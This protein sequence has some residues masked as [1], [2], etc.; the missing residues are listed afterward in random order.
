MILSLL[1]LACAP[2]PQPANTWIVDGQGGGHFTT[3]QAAIDAS[4]PGDFIVVHGG[5]YPEDLVVHTSVSIQGAAG[6][7]VTIHPATSD[8]GSG[9]G[10][11]ILTTTQSCRVEA[12]DVSLVG[13]VFDGDNPGLGSGI[14][15]RNGVITN[16]TNGP[17]QR[18]TVENC[19]VRNIWHRAVY[20]SQ[21]DGHLFRGNRVE[22]AR[23]VGLESAGLMLYGASGTVTGNV[24]RDCGIGVSTHA[25]SS[26]DVTVNDVRG[27][28]LGVLAN[29]TRAASAVRDNYFG[30][31]AQGVQLIGLGADVTVAG[32]RFVECQWGVSFFG[33]NGRGWIEDNDFDGRLV[34]GSSGVFAT[35][36]LT[37][38]GQNDVLGHAVRNEFHGLDAALVFDETA[39]SQPWVHG[40]LVGGAPADANRFRGNFGLNLL[41]QG[42]DD[43][44]SAQANSWGAATLA[45]IEATVWHQLDDPLLG[46]VDYSNPVIDRVV[47]DDDGAGDY[48]TI[49]EGIDN[50]DTGGTVEILPGSYPGS[51]VIPRA[52]VLQGSGVDPNPALGTNVSGDNP[53]AGVGND[54]I[55]V[56]GADV[57]IRDLRV[58][59]WSAVHGDRYGAGIVFDHTSGG[60][61]AGVKVERAIYG[62]YSYYSSATRVE[63]SEVV[64][65]GVDLGLGGGIFFRQSTGSIGGPGLG[66]VA[67][68]CGGTGILSHNASATLIEENLAKTCALGFL[69]NGAAGY[70]L[71]RG[72]AAS[73]CSQGF[74]ALA[75]NAPV[76][77][78]DNTAKVRPGGSAFTLY[79]L[80]GQPYQFSGNAADGAGTA[81]YGLY[82]NPNTTWG[83]SDIHASFRDN[84]FVDGDYGVYLDETGGSGYQLDLD[85]DGAGGGHNRLAG[86]ALAS[87]YLAGCDDPLPMRHNYWGTTDSYVIENRV[88]HQ[89]DDPALG[90]VDYGFPRLPEPDLRVDP[91]HGSQDYK[92]LIVVTGTPGLR[93]GVAASKHAGTWNTPYGTLEL[94][95][96]RSTILIDTIMPASGVYAA[97]L[98]AA[99]GAPG[100]W[101]VQGVTTGGFGGVTDLEIVT[102]Q[103]P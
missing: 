84:T 4:A 46:L 62:I 93:F 26:G 45:G 22:N 40:L 64:D 23:M 91:V 8:V 14:D 85:F 57:Q 10:S 101:R 66:N 67:R 53:A 1:L 31:C 38:W 72:N 16:Y 68:D 43:D 39:A 86:H 89:L 48:L 54:V 60:L 94:D 70:T 49:Q 80:G 19:V 18:L 76:D 75:N 87:V 32:N 55:S 73:G 27:C 96:Y 36:D 7:L 77:F 17:W 90:L 82:V 81:K 92:T 33:S 65:C 78:L 15:A 5:V 69:S 11:Q 98:A 30:Q 47:V 44:L 42:C 102:L 103:E 56:L 35:T 99:A 58:D 61:A 41:L 74:Q 12:D 6:E 37:P 100:V 25:G 97:R 2:A 52:M 20:G 13:L 9:F 71:F 51:L 21:G 24:V 34:P 59:A 95:R 88:H 29:G 3:I 50:V 79:G 63:D 83:S 28:Q